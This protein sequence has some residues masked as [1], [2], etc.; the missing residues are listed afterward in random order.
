[1]IYLVPRL[2]GWSAF[3]GFS[4]TLIVWPVN[5]YLTRR[6]VRINKKHSNASDKRMGVL[7]ELIAAVSAS[8]KPLIRLDQ[9]LITGAITP[10]LHLFL[11]QT[12]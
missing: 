5:T 10:D 3:A 1:M 8:S 6:R 4:V 7:N 2:L 11:D 12:H 9:L